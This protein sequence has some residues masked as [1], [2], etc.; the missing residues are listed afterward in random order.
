LKNTVA[1]RQRSFF[2]PRAQRSLQPTDGYTAVM[3]PPIESD[4]PH[5]KRKTAVLTDGQRCQHCGA[6]VCDR[7]SDRI[8]EIDELLG[9][10]GSNHRPPE[11]SDH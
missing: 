5:C 8:E 9:D 6:L 7:C 11:S 10:D 2:A 3:E 4:C 1:P